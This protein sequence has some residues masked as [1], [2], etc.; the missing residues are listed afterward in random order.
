[1][2]GSNPDLKAKQNNS[3]QNALNNYI[4]D[5]GT[6]IYSRPY[7]QNPYISNYNPWQGTVPLPKLS[8]M[9]YDGEC[10]HV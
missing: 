1:M 2:F 3:Y 9:E 7:A 5:D 10:A 6:L 8:G 4:M